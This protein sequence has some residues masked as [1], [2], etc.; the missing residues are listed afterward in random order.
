[1]RCK[2]KCLGLALGT[3]M[4]VTVMGTGTAFAATQST[5]AKTQ[6]EKK[7]GETSN[8]KGGVESDDKSIKEKKQLITI[9]TYSMG[10]STK[11]IM[12]KSLLTERQLSGKRAVNHQVM[13]IQEKQWKSGLWRKVMI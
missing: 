3:V 6:T 13:I 11:L 2:M 1:M 4:I 9:A 12:K 5:K 10:E 8:G 7:A